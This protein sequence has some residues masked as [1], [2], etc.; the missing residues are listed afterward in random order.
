[1]KKVCMRLVSC[2]IIVSILVS[3]A[4]ISVSANSGAKERPTLETAMEYFEGKYGE[5]VATTTYYFYMPDEWR[6]EYNDYYDGSD[7]DSCMLGVYWYGSELCLPDDYPEYSNG[8]PGYAVVTKDTDNV[9]VANVPDDVHIIVFNNLVDG[10]MDKTLPVY[11][12]AYQIADASTIYNGADSYGF[13]PDG[14]ESTDDMIFVV[15]PEATSENLYNGKVIYNGA[16]FYYYGDGEYGTAPTKEEAGVFVYSDGEFP[17][18]ELLVSTDSVELGINEEVKI[19]VNKTDVSVVSDDE[20]IAT[21]SKAE[22]GSFVIKAISEGV[23]YVSLS[24]ENPVTSEIESVFVEVEVSTPY[25]YPWSMNLSVGESEF[26]EKHGIRE[27]AVWSSSNTDVAVVDQQ[28]KV[29]ALGNGETIVTVTQDGNV[30]ECVITV[31]YE[32]DEYQFRFLEDNTIE[33][34]SGPDTSGEMKIPSEINGSAVTSIGE[35]AFAFSENITSVVVPDSVTNISDGA[36][37]SSYAL[38]SVELPEGITSLGY[39]AFENSTLL[40]NINIPE[41]LT[42]IEGYTFASCYSLSNILLPDS[43]KSINYNAFSDCINLTTILIPKNVEYIGEFAFYGCEKLNKIYVHQDN[44]KFYVE[45]EMLIAKDYEYTQMTSLLGGGSYSSNWYIGNVVVAYPQGKNV[46][47]IAVPEN[48]DAIYPGAFC[49]CKANTIVL[50][51]GIKCIGTSAFYGCS[52]LSSISFPSTVECIE[53]YAFFNCIS[54][55][56]IEL[57][58]GIKIIGYDAFCGCPLLKT[59]ELPIKIDIIAENAFYDTDLSESAK[60]TLVGYKNTYAEKYA[61]DNNFDFYNLGSAKAESIFEYTVLEDNTVSI[62]YYWGTTDVLEF[63]A[64][65][66]GKKVTK[67]D[68]EKI[69]EDDYWYYDLSINPYKAQKIVIPSGVVEIGASAFANSEM[70]QSITI[71]D[72]VKTIGDSAFWRCTALQSVVIPNGVEYIEPFTFEY[73]SSLTNIIIPY[74]VTYIDPYAF[75]DV[76][77]GFTICGYTDTVA[78]SYASENNF[79]FISLGKNPNSVKTTIKLK[80]SS[81]NIYIKETVNIKATVKN[82]VGETTYKSSNKKIATVSADGKVTAKKAGTV[83]I[84]VTNNGVS[85]VFKV[86]VKKPQLNKAVVK[87]KKGKSTTLKIT[88]KVGKATFKSSDSRIAVVN[89]KG[90]IVAKSKGTAII[91]VKTNGITLKCVVKVK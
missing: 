12:S 15:D 87:L 17:A 57:N 69:F 13:Y 83:K 31:P 44:E 16:W 7:L 33:I 80:K 78:E 53:S 27:D 79:E 37:Y 55:S 23:T 25:I 42:S 20:S 90:K 62:L 91:L 3:Y 56:E 58:E 18:T 26:I 19:S 28:G 60:P 38:R 30:Y 65:I 75:S 9:F 74:T 71:P 36:F 88:G 47:I 41:S 10:G 11:T 6:N 72:T 81:A 2:F 86:T 67:I 45:D 54:L 4:T 76:S 43:L 21:V 14:L 22:N 52:N 59:I 77:A 5:E 64:E 85:K 40:E 84:T 70:L 32:Y 82:G 61:E 51:E 39:A 1:M 66:N 35:Y 8:W 48:I 73:C 89:N 50:P 49:N 34:I 68:R 46:N 29:T 24:Y 63:P